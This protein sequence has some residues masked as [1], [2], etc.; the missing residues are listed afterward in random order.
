MRQTLLVAFALLSVACA[1]DDSLAV[2]GEVRVDAEGTPTGFVFDRRTNLLD[3]DLADPEDRRLR[4]RCTIGRDDAGED[5]IAVSIERAPTSA[6]GAAIERFSLRTNRENGGELSVELGGVTYDADASASCS[7]GLDY[8][9]R[10]DGIV[11]V[12][13]DCDAVD[14][15]NRSAS[16][17]GDL[18]FEGCDVE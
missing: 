4:G 17:T 12:T 18:A 8:A 13:F 1:G 3:P 7:I 9:V 6:E 5:V 11:G 10:S 14:P 15:T 2:S 16:V